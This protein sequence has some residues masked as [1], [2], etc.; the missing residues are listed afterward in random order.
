MN[1][2]HIARECPRWSRCSV[3]NCPLDYHAAHPD[4]KEHKC[5]MEKSVRIRIGAKYPG[6]LPFRGMTPREYAATLAFQRKP[7]AVRLA[8]VQRGKTSLAKL[9]NSKQPE[10]RRE[11]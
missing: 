3:N 7:V 6:E 10:K 2:P 11:S 5:P 4:D 1:T 9:H 8:M